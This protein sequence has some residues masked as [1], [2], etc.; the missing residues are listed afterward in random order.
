MLSPD[1][2]LLRLP[3]YS[4]AAAPVKLMKF[5]GYEIRGEALPPI[6]RQSSDGIRS[7]PRFAIRIA[8]GEARSI[9][10]HMQVMKRL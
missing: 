6:F 3:D 1:G 2:S 7:L 10:E 9:T 4:K 8:H 5:R